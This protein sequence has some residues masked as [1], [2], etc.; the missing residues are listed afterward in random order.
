M[1]VLCFGPNSR[2]QTDSFLRPATFTGRPEE[3][4][5]LKRSLPL[6]STPTFLKCLL[7]SRADYAKGVTTMT[8]DKSAAGDPSSG[9]LSYDQMVATMNRL[10]SEAAMLQ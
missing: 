8:W 7:C 2:G 5:E 1:I 9:L 4:P 6:R 3:M 10:I